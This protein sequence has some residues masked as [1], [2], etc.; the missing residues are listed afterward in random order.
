MRDDGAGEGRWCALHTWQPHTIFCRRVSRTP[1]TP[2][3]RITHTL[4]AP[5]GPRDLRAPHPLQCLTSSAPSGPHPQWLPQRGYGAPLGPGGEAAHMSW[6]PD[7]TLLSAT[8]LNALLLVPAPRSALPTPPA[9]HALL[10]RCCRRRWR[11]W[12]TPHHGS[13][14]RA[15]CGALRVWGQGV[16]TS[17]PPRLPSPPP[18]S[19]RPPCLLSSARLLACGR[20]CCSWAPFFSSWRTTT[21]CWTP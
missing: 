2:V 15:R 1:A 7:V 13:T 20:S 9:L 8:S 14:P 10:Y 3:H 19:C 6:V 11:R 17:R 16:G 12:Q 4:P 5:C 21:R 18:P